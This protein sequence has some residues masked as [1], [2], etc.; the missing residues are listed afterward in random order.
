M[1]VLILGRFIV[2]GNMRYAVIAVI[3][4]VALLMQP[5]WPAASRTASAAGI[6]RADRVTPVPVQAAGDCAKIYLPLILKGARLSAAS[7]DVGATSPPAAATLI[8]GP[9][10]AII[11]PRQGWMVSGMLFFAAQPLNS[12]GVSSVAFQAGSTDLGTDST[13]PDGFKVFLDADAFPA[14]P[15]QLT[16]TASGPCG[17]LTKTITV[18]NVPNPPSSGTIGSQ[19]GVFA[20][21]IGS[22]IAFPPGGVPDGTGITVTEKTQEQVT[23]ETGIDWE[24][25]GV[26]FLGAQVITST[27]P[28]SLPLMVASAGFGPRVQP[29]QAVVNYQIFPDANGDGVDELVVVN[30]ASVA[31]NNDVIADPVP[32][33]QVD[34]VTAASNA[35]I[36]LVGSLQDSI[37]GPPGMAIEFESTGFNP[38]SVFGNIALFRS[39]V[40]DEVFEVPGIVSVDPENITAQ[41][42]TVL[43]PTLTPGDV[44]L[45]LR[46]KGTGSTIGPINITVEPSTPLNVPPSEIVDTFLTRS[47]S[48]IGSLPASQPDAATYRDQ[49]VAKLIE[50][51][52]LFQQLATD[53]S[54]EAQQLLTDIATAIENSGI[55]AQLPAGNVS[56]H[57]LDPSNQRILEGIAAT[58]GVI[59]AIGAVG[60]AVAA[61]ELIASILAI[62]ALISVLIGYYIWIENNLE[63]LLEEQFPRFMFCLRNPQLCPLVLRTGMGSAPPPGG[64]GAG[65]A[66]APPPDLGTSSLSLQSGFLDQQAGRV[67][68]K[69]RLSGGANLPFT[70]VTDAGGYFFIP[71]IPEGQP[72]VA[73]AFDTLTGQTRT[74]EGVGPPT[75]ESVLMFFDFFSEEPPVPFEPTI[76]W[77][78]GGDGASWLDPLNWD[79]DTLPGPADQVLIDVPGNITVTHAAAS[80]GSTPTEITSLRSEEAIV[81][82]NGTLS[83][84]ATA[85]ITNAFT[86][87]DDPALLSSSTL[88]GTGS[89]VVNGPLTW[90]GGTMS[91]PGQ[92]IAN[93]GL[94]I[95]GAEDKFLSGRTL[96]NS[97]LASW[98]GTGT[99]WAVGGGGGILTNLAGATFQIESDTVFVGSNSAF[100]NAGTLIKLAGSGTTQFQ[101]LFNNPGTVE[102]QSG[103]LQLRGGGASDG[104]FE[105]ASGAT[106]NIDSAYTLTPASVVTGGG[107]VE[108]TS[109]GI[110]VL[111][112]YHVTGT[113]AIN[114]GGV[115]FDGSNP[116]TIPTL[117]LTSGTLSGSTDI[118][119]TDVMS[120]TGGTMSGPAQT[121]VNGTLDITQ[122]AGS[123]G[124][125]LDARTLVNDGA[126]TWSGTG[127]IFGLNGATIINSAGATFDLSADADLVFS[128]GSPMAF[129]NEGM[130]TKSG[131]TT[132]RS[133]FAFNNS[134]TVSVISGTLQLY[135]GGASTGSF[136][137][138]ADGDLNFSNQTF[139]VR[140]TNLLAGSAV[141]GAGRVRLVGGTVNIS[142]TYTLSGTTEVTGGTANFAVDATTGPLTFSGGTL[143]GNGTVTANGLF[144]WTGA[145][146]S[147]SGRTVANGGLLIGGGGI[148]TLSG[149]TL[150]NAGAGTWTNAGVLSFNSGAV[151]NNLTGATFDI[152]NDENTSG[153]G[154]FNNAGTLIKSA[155]PGTFGI[156]NP[157]NNS[158][159]VNVSSGTLSFF[160]G[161]TQSAGATILGGGNIAGG[162][163]LNIQGGSLSGPGTITGNVTNAGQVNP[164][165]IGA[166]GVL[167]ITGTYSQAATGALNIELGGLSP[168]QFDQLDVGG[169]AT[170]DGTLNVS[171]INGF[172]PNSGDTFQVVNYGSRSDVFATIQGPYTPAYNA[173]NLTIQRQ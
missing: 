142:G 91:G 33:I 49:A 152:Q 153:S 169:N 4:A 158:G 134:G 20:S 172:A 56:S 154:V 5:L 125:R 2:K 171:Q 78:G 157:F 139:G 43:I 111:G 44:T 34:Q 61:G 18:N 3:L 54:P 170:L 40:D 9:E 32:Q 87:T 85:I 106:L 173:T 65:N 107:L 104:G 10:F 67:V 37:S 79:T 16:A 163:T 88:A 22:I 123:G 97:G 161:Y 76:Q 13:P 36:P 109:S 150:D 105:V 129:I 100:N 159:T 168:G 140:Q 128:S 96:S 45:T 92:T 146:M 1:G 71:L 112:T 122:V 165:G 51:R 148:K 147:G 8:P 151:F 132:T 68:V 69:V 110:V 117:N 29:G 64:N 162:G 25:L 131:S 53:T 31:P 75:G 83:I 84:S 63:Q 94:T 73:T 164:G 121:I 23:A 126:A 57:K 66:P 166:S 26:T 80:F 114:G 30:M 167:T 119:V 59:V 28:I 41:T 145:T 62:I 82:S 60:L 115:S 72:F 58:L 130:L 11:S 93:G 113:T 7:A 144:T 50:V 86:L 116:I 101:G 143:I 19:G 81:L 89:L 39:S 118:T 15:L 149:R 55:M 42:F 141:T 24:A 17:Q 77:D 38:V 137:V 133:T 135:G 95:T 124:K 35:G 48:F 138:Q 46:N 74:F 6:P 21:Q 160:N 99:I 27:A 14:G 70:G 120:W 102:I 127:D 156:H 52:P 98:D 47:I 12:A 108:F 136:A 90:D 155:G 103:T